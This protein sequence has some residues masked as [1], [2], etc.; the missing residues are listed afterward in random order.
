MDMSQFREL[1]VAEARELLGSFGDGILALEK[2]G[3][4]AGVIDS[5]FRNAHSIKGMAAS[6]DY[7]EIAGLAHKMEELMDRIRKGKIPFGS[8]AADLLLA[9]ADILGRLVDGVAEGRSGGI[10]AAPLIEKLLAYDG[11]A[12]KPVGEVPC[13]Q[14]AMVP[15]EPAPAGT[16]P[17]P[18]P[19]REPDHDAGERVRTVR[20]R[21][22]L[23]DR[24]VSMA[25]ELVTSKNRLVELGEELGSDRLRDAVGD[26]SR[27]VRE[28]RTE[29]MA[30]RMMPFSS[31]CERLP[32]M[33]RD[34][35]RRSGKQAILEIE[36]REQEL[37]RGILELLSDPL[38]H[39][40][41]N[42]VDHGIEPPAERAAVGKGA[43]GRIVLK[44]EREK[45]H[46]LVTVADDGQGMDPARL[47]AAAEEKGLIPPGAGKTL[48][49]QEAFLLTCLPGFSTAGA[50]TDVSGRGVGMDAVQAAVRR[51]GGTLAIRS[52]RGRGSAIILRLPLT[53]A[54]IPVL[55]ADCSSRT[56]AVPVSAVQRT[57][58]LRRGEIRS[59]G[60]RKVFDLDGE[61]VPL[62]GLGRLLGKAHGQLA[63]EMV[64]VIV[65]D[66]G[67]RTVGVAVDRFLGQ[68][69]VFVRPLGRPLAKARGLAGGAILGDGRLIF[70][71]DLPD[72]LAPL[73][74]PR[75]VSTP[76]PV[77]GKGGTA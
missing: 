44:V 63:G 29:V 18:L 17:A 64:P 24:L 76:Y 4:N 6:M 56:V 34:L 19:A 21:S 61:R 36:G 15:K 73:L 66:A 46:V 75:P 65:T 45:D 10:D 43:E 48:T 31:I 77:F 50:V 23:L 38:V 71:L 58:E 42:A 32:R 25:G 54:I 70:I 72:L 68:T 20:V 27:L 67:G 11:E 28:L 57:V 55:L 37:D 35:A 52:E 40:L 26:L 5:L 33:V 1:F 41:R 9:G 12:E 13:E 16:P 60:K 3:A 7:P 8:G 69:E 74:R 22:D 14:R 39:I 47:A 62:V 2:D 49:D 59:E 51:A 53:V 30:V